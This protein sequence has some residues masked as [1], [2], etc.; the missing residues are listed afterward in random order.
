[1]ITEAHILIGPGI[2]ACEQGRRG[3]YTTTAE[4]VNELA[5]AADERTLSRVVGR[6]GRICE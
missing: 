5:E 1:M 3:R 6:Y 2:A 4:L